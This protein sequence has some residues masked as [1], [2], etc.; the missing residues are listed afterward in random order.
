MKP[1]IIAL[2]I[3]LIVI[4]AIVGIL[5]TKHRILVNKDGLAVNSYDNMGYITFI[6]TEAGCG[7]NAMFVVN[8]N[9]VSPKVI[10]NSLSQFVSGVGGTWLNDHQINFGKWTMTKSKN[11]DVDWFGCELE[12]GMAIKYNGILISA[13]DKIEDVIV[14]LG[15]TNDNVIRDSHNIILDKLFK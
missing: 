15:A 14:R 10:M 1:T 8:G 3:I 5:T 13:D 2:S 9:D 12:P 11:G 4:L 6:S 7:M